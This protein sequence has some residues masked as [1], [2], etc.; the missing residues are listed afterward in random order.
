MLDAHLLVQPRLLAEVL[1]PEG[2]GRAEDAKIRIGYLLIDE[3]SPVAPTRRVDLLLDGTDRDGWR[4]C[5]DRDCEYALHELDA[6][7]PRPYVAPD[8]SLFG[9]IKRL[10]RSVRSA[11]KA[12]TTPLAIAGAAMW[13]LGMSGAHVAAGASGHDMHWLTPAALEWARVPSRS[14]ED[15]EDKEISVV[16]QLALADHGRCPA[17]EPC[18]DLWAAKRTPIPP[19]PVG[20]TL[21]WTWEHGE[22]GVT[23]RWFFPPDDPRPGAGVELADLPVSQWWVTVERGRK[24]GDP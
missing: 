1:P 24:D 3:S 14:S 17:A 2:G 13:D 8:N 19:R 18:V 5:D 23:A 11:A 12:L 6:R 10:G 9:R 4:R 20:T 21:E 15:E 16:P 7:Y 22:C